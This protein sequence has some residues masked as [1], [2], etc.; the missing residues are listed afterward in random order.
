MKVI[1][2]DRNF[3]IKD[4]DEMINLLVV[5]MVSLPKNFIIL[6]KKF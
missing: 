2:Q 5:M 6:V 4:H 3:F 1:N